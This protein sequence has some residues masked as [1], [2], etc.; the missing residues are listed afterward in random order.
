[1]RHIAK[2]RT[3][4][5]EYI[6]EGK[7]VTGKEF[8]T[9]TVNLVSNMNCTGTGSKPRSLIAKPNKELT[10]NDKVKADWVQEVKKLQG[11]GPQDL[12]AIEDQGQWHNE[13]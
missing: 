5:I 4:K 10:G 11:Q 9:L 8:G 7:V 6:A 1:M 2:D 3:G 12:P 13:G